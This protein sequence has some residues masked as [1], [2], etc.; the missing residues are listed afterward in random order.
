MTRKIADEIRYLKRKDLEY[1]FKSTTKTVRINLR[2]PKITLKKLKILQY[3]DKFDTGD[4][5]FT[6]PPVSFIIKVLIN[7]AFNEEA[8]KHGVHY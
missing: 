8:K 6:K 4:S 3:S 7:K 1:S 5:K 2:V